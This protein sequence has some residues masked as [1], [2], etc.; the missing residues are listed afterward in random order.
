[1]TR[2][3]LKKVLETLA[4]GWP[5]YK[6]N[7]GTVR[8]AEL[9]L[10]P[11]DVGPVM[12]ALASYYVEGEAFAPTVGQLVQRAAALAEGSDAPTADEALDEV[13]RAIAHVGA[14]RTPEWS[15]PAVERAVAAYGGWQQVCA[16]DNPD[17]FRAQF[18][19]LYASARSRAG[20]Q[21]AVA[22]IGASWGGIALPN[23]S[24]DR[25]IEAG[26]S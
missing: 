23:L 19:K 6:A 8:L 1:M 4:D 25:A 16:N 10:L 20:V 14:Y 12:A 22:A 2:D 11:F 21:Q 24:A 9:L 13:W 17:A 7:R 5:N 18:A 15:H 3:E 26:S